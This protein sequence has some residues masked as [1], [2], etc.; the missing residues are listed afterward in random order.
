MN[1]SISISNKQ[2]SV[3]EYRQW[4]ANYFYFF[5][6]VKAGIINILLWNSNNS[7]KCDTDNFAII[8]F[9]IDE[10]LSNESRNTLSF[11]LSR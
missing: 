4:H 9:V 2:A 11:R 6:C 8:C 3:G 7:L 1:P 5:I 10:S